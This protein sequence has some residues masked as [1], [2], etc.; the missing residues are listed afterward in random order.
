MDSRGSGASKLI[1]AI[2]LVMFWAVY[3][4]LGALIGFPITLI[5]R[6]IDVLWRIAMIGARLGVR[7]VGI[8]VN[9]VG[10]EQLDPKQPYLYMSNHVS[11][12]DP[13][14]IVPLLERQT[15][16]MAKRELFSIPILG[17]A[18]RLGNVVPVNRGNRKAAIEG[19]RVAVDLLRSG[20]SMLL[21]PE[22][23]RSRDG[24]LLP[25]KKG[26]FHIAVESGVP[27]VPITMVGSHEAWPKGEFSVRSGDITAVFHTPIYP[28]D[29]ENRETLA[30]A[31]RD[32]I[33]SALPESQK[34]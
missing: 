17:T 18:L 28:K 23:T 15:S 2:V 3:V 29:F 9:A 14:I 22:G 27:I 30:I 16:I 25:F 4:V 31:V 5:T 8:R 1:R 24:K 26:P 20:K 6:K 21:Y 13:P 11:N 7:L 10:R 34:N 33:N 32:A 19:V 12:L